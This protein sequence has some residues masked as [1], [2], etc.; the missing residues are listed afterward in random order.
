[1]VASLVCRRAACDPSGDW[2]FRACLGNDP[3][4]AIIRSSCKSRGLSP[5]PSLCTPRAR[6]QSGGSLRGVKGSSPLSSFEEESAPELRPLPPGIAHA[7]TR[8]ALQRS[9][10]DA[11]NSGNAAGG[12]P[13]L[14]AARHHERHQAEGRNDHQARPSADRVGRRARPR[15]A[16][17]SPATSSVAKPLRPGSGRGSETAA[18]ARSPWSPAPKACPGR[19]LAVHPHPPVRVPGVGPRAPTNN[20]RRALP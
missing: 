3:V 7:G 8:S 14:V 6:E 4:G 18:R 9:R 15:P 17:P 20:G 10:S 19:L 12:Q 16:E 5:R 11:P 13:E 2:P 1:M